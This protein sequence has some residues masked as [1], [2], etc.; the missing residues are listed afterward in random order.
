MMKT[1]CEFCQLNSVALGETYCEKCN[2]IRAAMEGEGRTKYEVGYALDVAND[3]FNA[4]YERGMRHYREWNEYVCEPLYKKWHSMEYEAVPHGELTPVSVL[5][6]AAGY[7]IGRLMWDSE[8]GMWAPH[9][10]VSGYYKTRQ[11]AERDLLKYGRYIEMGVV[12]F[13]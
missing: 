2:V 13:I 1:V 10:R 7:Y 9:S 8:I 12:D 6:S 5:K 3:I 4:L 11:E